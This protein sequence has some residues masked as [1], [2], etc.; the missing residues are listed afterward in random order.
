[1]RRTSLLLIILTVTSMLAG[2]MSLRVHTFAPV[3]TTSKTVTVPPGG[4]LTGA[5]KEALSKDGWKIAVYRG[6]DITEGTL[7][8]N[9][10]LERSKSFNTRYAVF[11]RWRQFDTCFPTFEPAYSFDISM[12]DNTSASEVLTLSGHGC[13]HKIVAKFIDGLR[14]SR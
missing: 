5:V 14:A 6:P 4:G 13:E 1:M 9:T 10:R 12:V 3:D 8:E 11:I 7:G 2:C